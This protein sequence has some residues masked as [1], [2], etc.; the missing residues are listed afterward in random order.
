MNLTA[1]NIGYNYVIG[2]KTALEKSFIRE[3]P[4]LNNRYFEF[5][6]YTI[7][8][9]LSLKFRNNFQDAV[10]G[11]QLSTA[12]IWNNTLNALKRETDNPC[13]L[14]ILSPSIPTHKAHSKN[15]S[16]S[17]FH[18]SLFIWL[19]FAKGIRHRSWLSLNHFP[20]IAGVVSYN[21]ISDR[22]TQF[23]IEGVKFE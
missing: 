9:I 3:C 13:L 4:V 7:I 10:E 19:S 2:D 11:T 20:G 5:V 22:G 18:T 23:I 8:R 16:R 14:C 21:D 12:V 6:Y 1:R 15:H 17:S